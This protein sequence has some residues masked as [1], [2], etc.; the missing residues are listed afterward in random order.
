MENR[1]K[2][3]GPG[4]PGRVV[5]LLGPPGS[6]KGTQGLYLAEILSVPVISTGEILRAECA[7]E[8]ASGRA[9]RQLLADGGLA[10]DETVNRLVAARLSGGEC[11]NGCVLDGYPRTVAQA[12][13]L[14]DLLAE[15]GFGEPMVLH[16]DVAAEELTRRLTGRRQCPACGHLYNV[17]F[18]PPRRSGVCDWDGEALVQRADD[19]EEIVRQ[20]LAI[21]EGTTKPVIDFYRAGDYRRVM[22]GQSEAE[23]RE[24][25]QEALLLPVAAG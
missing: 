16:L 2:S 3:Y 9:L 8:T 6:G 7:R 25:I 23:V 20:R 11:G 14:N 5:V 10:S 12:A 1:L 19:R 17:Y 18:R 21:Y 13:F 4:A 15:L 24:A 22:A